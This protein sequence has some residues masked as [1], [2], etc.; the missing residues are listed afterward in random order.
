MITKIAA[1]V[2]MS[3]AVVVILLQCGGGC[4]YATS[5]TY[6]LVEPFADVQ[7]V[8]YYHEDGWSDGHTWLMINGEA[9]ECMP[10]GLRYPDRVP[11]DEP[12]YHG[13]IEDLDRALWPGLKLRVGH[14]C[15]YVGG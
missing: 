10:L 11:Y 12:D 6:H 8:G 7:I 5:I 13:T 2:G 4:I 3:C 15:T 1:V 9:H 14:L